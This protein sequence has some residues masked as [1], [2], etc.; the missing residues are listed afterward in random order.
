LTDNS[1]SFKIEEDIIDNYC[2]FRS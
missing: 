1:N 2:R